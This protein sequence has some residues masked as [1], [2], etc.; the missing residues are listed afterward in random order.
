MIWGGGGKQTH[1]R[2]DGHTHKHG[3]II[4]PTLLTKLESK[5]RSKSILIKINVK[6][7]L[8]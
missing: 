3:D 8:I 1:A 4:S 2:T 6:I 7:K 5:S